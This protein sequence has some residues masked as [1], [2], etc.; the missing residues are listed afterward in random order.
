MPANDDLALESE[1][2]PELEAGVLMPSDISADAQ[3]PSGMTVRQLTPEERL[4]YPV[5][6]STRND[7]L[8][9]RE[10]GLNMVEIARKYGKPYAYVVTMSRHFGV[11]IKAGR[12]DPERRALRQKIEKEMATK[13]DATPGEETTAVARPGKFGDKLTRE[14]LE[15]EIQRHSVEEIAKMAGCTYGTVNYYLKKFGI[16]N[17]HKRAKPLASE[18]KVLAKSAAPEAEPLRPMLSVAELAEN[19]Q[20]LK[21]RSVLEGE[22][23]K[24]RAE[25]EA[26]AKAR[27]SAKPMPTTPLASRPAKFHRLIDAMMDG[28][29]PLEDGWSTKGLN[30]WMALMDGILVW[31]YKVDTGTQ[32]RTQG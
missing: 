14:F 31:L 30:E 3:A 10:A 5:E 4:R 26:E 9:D 18:G 11:G 22:R 13:V 23:A 32:P 19:G 2:E 20:A 1:D 16:K 12:A 6:R 17:P 15:G 8:A 25:V 29:P 27:S 28:L 21:R 7:L 24:I